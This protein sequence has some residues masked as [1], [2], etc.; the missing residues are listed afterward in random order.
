MV[1]EAL[2]SAWIAEA[3]AAGTERH[4]TRSLISHQRRADMA[5]KKKKSGLPHQER[6]KSAP[7]LEGGA[8]S[9]KD[10]KDMPAAGPH[11]QP[12]LTDPQKTPGTGSLPELG[13]DDVSP[14]MS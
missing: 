14:G 6:G 7:P 12:D 8:V 1:A 10:N 3:S 13:N 4:A 2:R 11:A 5:T 9:D